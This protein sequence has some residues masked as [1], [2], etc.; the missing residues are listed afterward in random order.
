MTNTDCYLHAFNWYRTRMLHRKKHE[1]TMMVNNNYGGA[2]MTTMTTTTM[3][4]NVVHVQVLD[5]DVAAASA[6]KFETN[7]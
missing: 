2:A 4:A 6:V 1:N 3:V 7:S 5:M